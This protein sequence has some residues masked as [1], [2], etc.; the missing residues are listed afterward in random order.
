MNNA[1]FMPTSVTKL[2]M[3]NSVTVR[4]PVLSVQSA[5]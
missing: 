5:P 3:S 1:S 4:R 2:R